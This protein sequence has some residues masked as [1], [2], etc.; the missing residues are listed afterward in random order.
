MVR[1]ESHLTEYAIEAAL[2]GA[3]MV[4]ACAVTALLEHPGVAAALPPFPTRSR[5]AR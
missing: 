3:F 1:S 2:L 5:A 4:S